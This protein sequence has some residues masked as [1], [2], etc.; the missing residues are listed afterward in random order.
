M[1]TYYSK[2]WRGN[3]E[4]INTIIKIAESNDFYKE[5]VTGINSRKKIF[6]RK[7]TAKNLPHEISTTDKYDAKGIYNHTFL[8]Y[9]KG[10]TEQIA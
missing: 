9:M 8:N 10:Y 7:K 6:Q 3:H 1:L 4:E 5:L 2:N